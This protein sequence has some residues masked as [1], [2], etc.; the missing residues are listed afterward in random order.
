MDF[1]NLKKN[2]KAKKMEE[3]KSENLFEKWD[4]NKNIFKIEDGE[5]EGGTWPRGGM[6][7]GGHA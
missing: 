3:L 1:W 7:K 5:L 2:A 4:L 6:P